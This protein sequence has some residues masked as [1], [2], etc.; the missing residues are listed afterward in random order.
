MSVL[1]EV[2]QKVLLPLKEDSRAYPKSEQQTEKTT[3][4][5]TWHSHHLGITPSTDQPNN[6]LEAI[7]IAERCNLPI[8]E[9]FLR[10]Y[11]SLEISEEDINADDSAPADQLQPYNYPT[12]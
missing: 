6:L 11:A 2:Y 3:T 12:F 9:H 7:A 1:T 10:N 4:W 5:E 8:S